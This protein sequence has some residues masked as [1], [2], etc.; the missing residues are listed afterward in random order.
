MGT[1]ICTS[2]FRHC[3]SYH[4]VVN[5]L[6]TTQHVFGVKKI[7]IK[8]REDLSK[9]G[10]FRE[11]LKPFGRNPDCFKEKQERQDVQKLIPSSFQLSKSLSFVS[12]ALFF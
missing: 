2:E 10:F 12:I 6:Y 4:D 3:S 7:K 9:R 11:H 5:G 1:C 8:K